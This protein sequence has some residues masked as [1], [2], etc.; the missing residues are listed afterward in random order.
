[1]VKGGNTEPEP[2]QW[3]QV[4]KEPV[5]ASS[6]AGAEPEAA[7]DA[8]RKGWLCIEESKD[9]LEPASVD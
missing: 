5:Q 1:M 8:K 9:D 4:G 6:H 2:V 3:L 7:L